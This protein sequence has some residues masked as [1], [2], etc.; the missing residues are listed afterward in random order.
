M[1]RTPVYFMRGLNSVGDEILRLGPIPCGT[2]HDRF[3]RPFK[4]LKMLPLLGMGRGSAESMGERALKALK[5]DPQYQKAEK[6]H[7]VGHSLGGLVARYLVHDPEVRSKTLSVVTIGTPHRGTPAAEPSQTHNFL[8]QFI[9]ELVRA[10]PEKAAENYQTAR[11]EGAMAFAQRYPDVEGVHY[12]SLI[13]HRPYKKLP[14]GF[15]ILEQR[16]NVKRQPSD[17]LIPAKSQRWGQVLDEVSLDHLEQIG[18]CG[19]VTPWERVRF[20]LEF[21]RQC[22]ILKAYW[23]SFL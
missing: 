19:H 6:I 11:L 10:A 3:L 18:F 9:Y 17:G 23:R 21:Q 5:A 8:S 12:A 2:Y 7:L 22:R 4:D 15:Q 1:E 14:L 13:G 20:S 16:N